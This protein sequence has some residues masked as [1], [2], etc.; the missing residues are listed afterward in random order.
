MYACIGANSGMKRAP[1]AMAQPAPKIDAVKRTKTPAAVALPMP[2]PSSR[3]VRHTGPGDP[4]PGEGVRAAM[5][6]RARHTHNS[7]VLLN[8]RTWYTKA[9]QLLDMT[10]K[11]AQ[12]CGKFTLENSVIT[13]ASKTKLSSNI[14][15]RTA[16]NL[17]APVGSP[18][19]HNVKHCAVEFCSLKNYSLTPLETNICT[20]L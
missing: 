1:T 6:N 7:A 3:A 14:H 15:V 2:M 10:A 20:A 18:E 8:G 17:A 19:S 9:T 11:V 4:C 12:R 5:A 16:P 13:A